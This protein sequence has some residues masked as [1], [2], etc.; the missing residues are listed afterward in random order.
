M[1]ETKGTDKA[2]VL[3]TTASKEE[4]ERLARL[5]L[6][7]RKVACVNIVPGVHSLFWWQGKLDSAQESL[8]IAK[9]RMALVPRVI[10]MVKGA[11]SYTVPEIIALPIMAGNDDYLEWID[12]ETDEG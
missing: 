12:R 9:T 5:L 2:V 10:A 8:L 6:D 1:T 4:A 11:H 7:Q 3:I